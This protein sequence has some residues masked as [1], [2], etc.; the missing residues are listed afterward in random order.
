V[1]APIVMLSSCGNRETYTRVVNHFFQKYQESENMQKSYSEVG[2]TPLLLVVENKRGLGRFR[3]GEG[4]EKRERC[5]HKVDEKGGN[6]GLYQK[7]QG[8]NLR[9]NLNHGWDRNRLLKKDGKKV[10]V[11]VQKKSEPARTRKTDWEREAE[12]EGGGGE[13]K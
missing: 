7:G 8:P 10:D 6:N 1:G 4:L 2:T 13:K 11:L 3:K 9:Q 12:M 5:S